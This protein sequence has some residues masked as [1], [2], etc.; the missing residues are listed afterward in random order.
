[1]SILLIGKS[2]MGMPDTPMVGCV[3]R[4]MVGAVILAVLYS[5]LCK[6]LRDAVFGGSHGALDIPVA[7]H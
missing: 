7:S 2:M 1:L 4:F 6:P 3:I 5:R